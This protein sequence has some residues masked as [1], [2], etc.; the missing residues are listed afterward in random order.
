[1]PQYKMESGH[2]DK[3][4]ERRGSVRPGGILLADTKDSLQLEKGSLQ[5]EKYSHCIENSL[6]QI[7][8]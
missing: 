6:N 3:S 4:L 5:L 1:M 7:K 2:V 8:M